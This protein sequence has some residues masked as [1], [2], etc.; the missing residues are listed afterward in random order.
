M[1]KALFVWGGWDGHEPK[2][3]MEVIAPWMQEAGFEVN[4]QNT[5]DA[6]L[7]EDKMA[8][9]EVI[10]QCWTM[11]EISKEQSA[12][13]TE[14]V[15]KGCGFAGWHGGMCDSFRQN[16]A[17]QFMTGANW[18]SHPDGKIDYDVKIVKPE[19]PIVAGLADFHMTDTE[20]Y[21][22]HVDPGNEILA[23]TTFT[24]P[25]SAPWVAGTVMPQVY[26]RMWGEGRIFYSAL[27][28]VAKDFDVPEVLTLTQR[29]ILWAAKKA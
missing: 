6:Y 21:Y 18:V 15:K 10:V 26:K 2:Q 5:L 14:T 3:C 11:G 8:E 27:G 25:E 16:T 17:Y 19:D 29:G 12:A 28:H 9:Y 13:L 7:E 4:I 24:A 20:Q 23:T 22:L 1:S